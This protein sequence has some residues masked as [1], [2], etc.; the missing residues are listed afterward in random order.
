M[1]DVSIYLSPAHPRVQLSSEEDLQELIDNGVLAESH[2]LDVKR[3]IPAKKNDELARDLAQFGIDGGALIVGVDEPAAGQFVLY[4]VLLAGLPERINQVARTVPDPAIDV[5]IT[6]LES[7]TSPDKG[8]LVVHVPPQPGAPHM[9]KGAYINRADRIKYVMSDPE[10]RRFHERRRPATDIGRELIEEEIARD[11]LSDDDTG[12][13]HLFLMAQPLAPRSEM[14]AGITDEREAWQQKL[15]EF[16]SPARQFREWSPNIAEAQ[17][18][19]LRVNGVGLS[20]RQLGT[21]RQLDPD[22]S[23]RTDVVDLEVRTDGGLRLYD[24]RLS[25]LH[26][27]DTQALFDDVLV[28]SAR[29]LV[30]LTAQAADV[31]GY[32]GN[33][34]L[35]IAVTRMQGTRSYLQMQAWISNASSYPSPRWS[36]TVEVNWAQLMNRPAWVANQLVAAPLR[37]LGSL[38]AYQTKLT[39]TKTDPGVQ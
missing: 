23:L 20:T 15:S 25:R 12:Q 30:A 11:P 22:G 3:E 34:V 36:K 18:Y 33:W 24:S 28:G 14:L 6:T 39:D 2:Y 1:W 29:Q 31:G 9:V 4:P 37:V 16:V 21:A 38:D 8:Y 32:L 19:A 35:A 13:A 17:Q 7:S 26:R 10:V 27:D 5:M